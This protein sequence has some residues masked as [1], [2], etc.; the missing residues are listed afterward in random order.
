M[1]PVVAIVG[2][3]NVGKSTLYNC[4]TRTRDALVADLPG[5]TRDRIYGQAE[6]EEKTFIVVDTGGIVGEDEGIT[7]LTEQQSQ[8][9]VQEADVILFLVDGKAGLHPVDSAIAQQL[10]SAHKK[11]ILVVNK[12][13]GQDENVAAADF[14]ALGISALYAISASHRRGINSLLSSLTADFPDT[15][16]DEQI[17]DD[18]G[19]CV[20]IIGRPNVGKSTLINRIVGQE[21]VLAHDMPG[22]T[23]DSIDVPFEHR[24][25]RYTL[26]DTAG[27][28]RRSKVKEL[29]ERFSVVKS[30]QA[31]EAC[32]VVVFVVDAQ[33]NISEQDL[34]LLGLVLKAGK[35]LIIA[36]NKWDN[37]SGYQRE[38][39]IKSLD[40]RLSFVPYAKQHYI[41]A[42]HG[43]GVG[44]LFPLLQQCYRSAMQSLKTADLTALLEL[45]VRQHPPPL[46][47]GRRIKLR[48]AHAGGH[49]PPTVV[50][51]G[52]QVKSVPGSYLRYLENFFRDKLKLVGTPIR[53]ILKSGENPYVKD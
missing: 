48:Y 21:R 41:S 9:A 45:A 38:Q 46:V 47:K 28:R 13:D 51:H 29:V 43:T 49:N 3:P 27:V 37:L 8:L 2:R 30:L 35:A 4:L 36:V 17:D 50:I 40:R 18:R 32:H 23:R 15:A 7:G 33:E 25:Q 31:I 34:K 11:V 10:R 16:S 44:D 26:I 24:G 14:H 22:T 19:I 6:F 52:N 20:A 1:I 5:V 12:T 53:L 42:L 39:V